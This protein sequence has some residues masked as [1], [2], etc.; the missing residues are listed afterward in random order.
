MN[1]QAMFDLIYNVSG[2]ISIIGLIVIV[3]LFIVSKIK[4]KK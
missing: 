2:T 1:S 3:I 4:N